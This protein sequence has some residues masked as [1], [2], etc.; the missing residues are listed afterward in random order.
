METLFEVMGGAPRIRALVDHFYD[1][2][3]ADPAVKTLRDMHPA[4]LT[5]SRDKLYE[6]L[7]GWS[8]GPP[9]Y[10]EKHGHP[11]LRMRHMPFAVDDRAAMEW[12]HCMRIALAAEVADPDIRDRLEQ[13]F[14]RIALHMRNRPSTT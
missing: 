3:D 1:V 10:M 11:R 14:T 13:N 12:M 4:D 2:M 9:L 6:F 7:S 8:G 5:T